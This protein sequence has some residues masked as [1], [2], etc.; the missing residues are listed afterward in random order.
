M[1]LFDVYPL[2]NITPVKGKGIH[3]YDDQNVEYLDLYGG[4][5]VISIG[6]SHPYYVEKIQ[7][8]VAN[9]GFYSNAIQNP[10]QKE[11]AT[12]LGELSGCEDY[13]LFLVNSGAEANEN[14]LK[15]A[16][17]VTNKS[18]VIAFK[19]SF[20]GRTSAAVAATDNPKIHAPLNK[21]KSVTFVDLEDKATIEAELKKGDVCAVIIEGI[22]GVGGLDAPTEQYLSFLSQKCK[23]HDA[24]LILDEI[25]SGYGRTGKFFAY[26]YANI[27]PDIITTA[28][29]M[30]NGFPIGGV[31]IHP[32]IKAAYGML[33]TTF[34]GNHL[35]CAAG[36]SVLD[37][38]EDEKLME[39]VLQVSEYLIQE[40]RSIPKIKAIKGKG[41]MLGVEFDF[42]IKEIR[43]QLLHEYHIF[44]GAS[45]NPNLLR[46]LPPLCITKEQFDPFLL[47]LKEILS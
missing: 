3:V 44:T 18:R 9:L 1:N 31:L 36:I 10:L 28:K 37:T 2:Y 11:L 32:S 6:H 4:H 15:V 13:N 30:G 16:S 29:G 25:Q 7:E 26:Q 35:A 19:N 14:A 41:L 24:I 23:E 22:Q 46:I 12:K 17:F 40:L 34:G 20:H 45:S 42:T 8:Q 43:A 21:Q 33:G 5:A 27:E 39:N 38:L 47:A